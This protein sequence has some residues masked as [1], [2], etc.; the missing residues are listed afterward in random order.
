MLK[1]GSWEWDERT[2]QPISYSEQM[3]EIFGV[4]FEEIKQSIQLKKHLPHTASN[5]IKS[6][7]CYLAKYSSES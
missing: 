4:D 3:A 6:L 2:D 7:R 5:S 1:V